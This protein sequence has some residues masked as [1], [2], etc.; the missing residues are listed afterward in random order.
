MADFNMWSPSQKE[1]L[2][3][4]KIYNENLEKRVDDIMN[5]LAQNRH[6]LDNIRDS[7]LSSTSNPGHPHNLREADF[8][9]ESLYPSLLR[10]P[11]VD[12]ERGVISGYRTCS[13]DRSGVHGDGFPMNL[14]RHGGVHGKEPTTEH[15]ANINDYDMI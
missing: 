10:R 15:P 4:A 3:Y 9:I 14:Y 12:R 1:Y 13:Y 11:L 7:G 6:I 2:E 5:I 8:D